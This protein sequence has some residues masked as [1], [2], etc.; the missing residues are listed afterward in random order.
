MAT[1]P[2]RG[3][4]SRCFCWFK[5]VFPQ[6][7]LQL[8]GMPQDTCVEPLLRPWALL[9][10]PSVIAWEDSPRSPCFHWVLTQLL[11][12]GKCSYPWEKVMA[13]MS[14]TWNSEEQ[15]KPPKIYL[16]RIT[17]GYW[18]AAA[19]VWRLEISL[20]VLLLQPAI[21]NS[22]C[23]FDDSL[24]MKQVPYLLSARVT[25]ERVRRDARA[26]LCFFL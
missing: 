13:L 22:F 16:G 15:K 9:K 12:W 10:W 4:N 3:R 20:S 23:I 24:F 17:T 25:G 26:H 14:G 19:Q 6:S 7:I 1:L 18:E 21:K 11:A 5:S 8:T 2:F